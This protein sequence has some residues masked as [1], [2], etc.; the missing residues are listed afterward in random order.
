MF[1]QRNLYR[2]DEED[3]ALKLLI[4]EDLKKVLSSEKCLEAFN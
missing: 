2:F 4:N 3:F 1:K